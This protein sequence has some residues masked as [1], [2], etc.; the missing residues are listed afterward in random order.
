MHAQPTWSI[1]CATAS[2]IILLLENKAK[3]LFIREIPWKLDYQE[4][5]DFSECHKRPYHEMPKK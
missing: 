2:N 5:G 1:L 3:Y 4:Q